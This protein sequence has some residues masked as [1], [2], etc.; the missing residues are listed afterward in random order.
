MAT[1]HLR[2]PSRSLEVPLN[3]PRPNADQVRRWLSASAV[4]SA[5]VVEFGAAGSA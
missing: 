1:L 5:L 4:A 3:Q 2:A